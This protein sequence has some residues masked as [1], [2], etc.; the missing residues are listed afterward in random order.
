MRPK[1]K[2]FALFAVFAAIGLV[3]ASGAFTTVTAERTAEVN[4]AGDGAALLAIQ[5]AD[6]ANG[7]QYARL[8]NGEVEINTAGNFDGDLNSAP[9]GVNNNATTEINKIINITNQGSQTVAIEIETT[10]GNSSA[11]TFY[12][13]S[14][15]SENI[16]VAGSGKDANHQLKLGPGDTTNVS[17][18]I[19]TTSLNLDQDAELINNVTI[20]ANATNPA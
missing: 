7:D 3:T 8:Q 11:V 15:Y 10:G 14:S 17:M 2:L 5:P 12:N 16:T 6:T 1:G 20:Y 4:T 18:K 19:D 9:N 13:D